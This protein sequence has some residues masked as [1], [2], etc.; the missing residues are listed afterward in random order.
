MI[1]A[2]AGYWNNIIIKV[3]AGKVHFVRQV[4]FIDNDAGMT[5]GG[6]LYLISFSQLRLLNNTS[7][8]FVNNTGR[9]DMP[10]DIQWEIFVRMKS[11]TMYF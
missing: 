4:S 11:K 10:V 7:L 5:A 6:A 3:R 1:I 8:S 9:Y 2:S